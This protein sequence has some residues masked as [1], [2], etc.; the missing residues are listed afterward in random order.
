MKKEQTVSVDYLEMLELQRCHGEAVNELAKLQAE[1]D[2]LLNRLLSERKEL[3]GTL[4]VTVRDLEVA[5]EAISR[6]H[7]DWFGD[8]KTFKTP[9]GVV[10]FFTSSELWIQN[11]ELT[12]SRLADAMGNGLVPDAALR[13]V[14]KINKEVLEGLDEKTL[15]DLGIVRRVKDNFSVKPAKVNLGKAISSAD[16]AEKAS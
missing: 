15:A 9:F 3:F 10:R 1:A 16:D 2:D 11:E 12:A 13:M 7:P 8:G 5:L 14:V 4:T 6:R